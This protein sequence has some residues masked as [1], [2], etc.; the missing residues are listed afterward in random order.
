V[1]LIASDYQ[2]AKNVNTSGNEIM[3]NTVFKQTR[4]RV[5]ARPVVTW[6]RPETRQCVTASQQLLV[7]ASSTAAIRSVRFLDG[8]KAITVD[9]TGVAGLY[10]VTWKRGTARRGA[11]R[12]VAVA[13]DA[14]G[15]TA[16]AARNVRVCGK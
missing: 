8:V 1:T 10:S 14:Q 3:P 15:R 9:R 12:L 11:H 16:S 13:R 2:E 7:L 6:L 4:L 5:V